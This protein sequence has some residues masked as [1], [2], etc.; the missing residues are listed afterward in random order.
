MAEHPGWYRC[1]ARGLK[2]GHPAEFA[3]PVETL[4]EI[5]PEPLPAIVE[6]LTRYSDIEQ[7]RR[8]LPDVPLIEIEKK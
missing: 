3:P 8:H 4:P 2:P 6:A 5:W 1:D 7:V